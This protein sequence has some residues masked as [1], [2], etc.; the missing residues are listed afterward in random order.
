VLRRH[1]I[2]LLQSRTKLLPRFLEIEA[3]PAGP[4]DLHRSRDRGIDPLDA[5]LAVLGPIRRQL[6]CGVADVF[7][8]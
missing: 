2:E 5:R 4:P 6:L 7:G 1:A 3:R 8:R